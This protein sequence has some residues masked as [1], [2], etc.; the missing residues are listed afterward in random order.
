MDNLIE[1][2]K[3]IILSTKTGN[4]KDNIY[5]TLINNKKVY[6]AT[7]ALESSEQYNFDN[8]TIN[9]FIDVYKQ[10]V[11]DENQDL[12]DQKIDA[13]L[14]DST[15]L[16]L[17]DIGKIPMLNKEEE[18]ELALKIKK[19]YN[20][21][22]ECL[23][24][25]N[26]LAKSNTLSKEEI[27]NYKKLI[28]R[29]EEIVSKIDEV[30]QS[31]CKS[32]YDLRNKLYK[33]CS[34]LKQIT[35]A[36]QELDYNKS[37]SKKNRDKYLKLIEQESEIKEKLDSYERKMCEANL[38]LVVSIAKNYIGSNISFLD[39]IQEGNLGLMKAVERYDC[40]KG[41]RFTT[42]ATW[43]IRQTIQRSIS[44][45][46]KTIRIPVHMYEKIL[47]TY[48]K[49][50][51][52]TFELGRVPTNEEL[53][54]YL[55]ISNDDLLSLRNISRDISSIDVPLK[56]DSDETIGSFIRD[57]GKNVEEE[58]LNKYMISEL[59]NSF[60]DIK[61]SENEKKVIILRYGLDNGEFKTLEQV[62][63][64]LGV[65]RERIRQIEE[66]ALIKIRLYYKG[67]KSRRRRKK[68]E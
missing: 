53:A 41:F 68:L 52:L 40:E 10:I 21:Y 47:K 49:E 5:E 33:L 39:L 1:S 24:A 25:K 35:I 63:A 48:K 65:T 34:V 13:Y 29:K 31:S 54:N 16:Y 51:E 11:E 64:M 57:D 26:R 20:L 28:K 38:R 56:D 4:D 6:E 42:Y 19:Y 7:K 62:G 17:A 8:Q 60:D 22:N 61:L 30:K 59:I 32:T 3:K 27:A 50:K 12:S 15:E 43:W 67:I 36:E 23:Y 55:N 9:G 44:D 14:D 58:V 45:I 66:K 2:Y 46:G 37:I 18:Y